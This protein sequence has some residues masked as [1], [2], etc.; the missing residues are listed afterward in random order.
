M[1]RHRL[2]TTPCS[3]CLGRSLSHCMIAAPLPPNHPYISP[4]PTKRVFPDY[5]IC[6]MNNV[7]SLSTKITI[8]HS[9][10]FLED[11]WKAPD[12]FDDSTRFVP[13]NEHQ[14][15]LMEYTK[16][17]ISTDDRGYEVGSYPITDIIQISNCI[18]S[19]IASG[20][21]RY[22]GAQQAEL[23]VKRLIMERGGGR[24]LV[25]NGEMAFVRGNSEVTWDMYHLESVRAFY[26]SIKYSLLLPIMVSLFI[27]SLPQNVL[28]NTLVEWP[29][30]RKRIR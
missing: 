29:L 8:D 12:D 16:S 3:I 10:L 23:L 13:R 17:L 7:R 21:H 18:D 5:G 2:K 15:K 11:E 30:S 22:V 20:E 26:I 19:W 6:S 25:E 28:A 24:S 1:L 14:R 4:R 27:V 9:D